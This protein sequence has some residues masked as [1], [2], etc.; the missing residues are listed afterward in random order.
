[1]TR[2]LLDSNSYFRLAQSIRPLLGVEFGNKRYCLYIT[3]DLD[4]EFERNPALQ[5]K[6][7]WVREAEYKANRQNT[8]NL[9]QNRQ[10][11]ARHLFDFLTNHART[12]NL[13]VSPVDVRTLCLGYMLGIPVITDDLDMLAL[14]NAFQIATMTTLDLVKL[15]L[16]ENHIDMKKVR[17]ICAYWQ[18]ERDLP[19]PFSLFRKQ[20]KNLFNEEP[21][22]PV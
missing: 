19:S 22:P 10:A 12:E 6:F 3:R 17:Q 15:M 9:P 2:I 7:H 1:P 13:S 8:L 4:K 21:P 18:Y 14:A 11:E 20:Y 16:D 5:T